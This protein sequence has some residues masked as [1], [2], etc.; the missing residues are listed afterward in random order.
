MRGASG[1]VYVNQDGPCAES[2]D[3]SDFLG[4]G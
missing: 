2:L 4:K 1:F 3:E